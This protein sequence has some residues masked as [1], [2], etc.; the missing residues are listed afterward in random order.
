[1]TQSASRPIRTVLVIE[2]EV[3]QQASWRREEQDF[4]SDTS[5][6][7]KAKLLCASNEEEAGAFLE[8]QRIDCAVI[9][10]RLPR[11]AGDQPTAEVGNS[12][13]QMI[14]S[15]AAMP[16]VLLSGHPDESRDE[17]KSS[18]TLI[19]E[20]AAGTQTTALNWLTEQEPLMAALRSARKEI[21]TQTAEIF[22]GHIWKRWQE[23]KHANAET[24]RKSLVR[25][26]ISHVGESLLLTPDGA[27]QHDLIEFYFVPPL[28]KERL[29]TGDVCKFD[30]KVMVILS[31]KCDMARMYPETILVAECK[32]ASVSWR[33]WGTTLSGSASKDKKDR[34]EAQLTKHARQNIDARRHFLPPCGENGPWLVD[35]ACLTTIPN[36]NSQNLLAGRIASIGPQFVPNLV[37]RFTAFIGRVGQPGLSVAQLS[38][39]AKHAVS[40]MPA[41]REG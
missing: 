12:I 35:F 39:S 3:D 14:F 32:D 21:R 36:D 8:E 28:N 26:I 9:D 22:Y 29:Q 23:A 27:E 13:F 2:D 37:Q 15:Y 5:K 38:E 34:A 33:E 16:V 41:A 6:P 25:Q 11:R 17:I 18:P 30:D 19:L 20:K 4:N 40:Q 1:M 10:L 24:I 31:P 7:F